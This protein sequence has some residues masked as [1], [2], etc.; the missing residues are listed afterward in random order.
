MA[1]RR[2]APAHRV[3]GQAHPRPIQDGG[4]VDVGEQRGEVAVPG[5]LGVEHGL[6]ERA[7]LQGVVGSH[8]VDRP[9][10]HDD[11]DEPALLEQLA[12]GGGVEPVEPRP[13]REVGIE[14]VLG[15]HPDQVRDRV[16]RRKRRPL[17]QELAGQRR[18]VEGTAIEDERRHARHHATVGPTGTL[19]TWNRP[20]PIRPSC[21]PSG[22]S[23][24]TARRRPAGCS[25]T[26]RPPG[27]TRCCATSRPKR[28]CRRLR[29]GGMSRA[30]QRPAGRR[31]GAQRIP[32]PLSCREGAP[33]PWAGALDRDVDLSLAAVAGAVAATGPP[34]LSPLEGTPVRASAV[35]APLYE[36]D[37]ET[38]IVLTRRAQDLRTHR[39]EV[40]F[41][42]GGSEPGDAD[43]WATALR[44]SH[45]E[46]ALDP[47]SVTRIGELDHLQTITSRSFIVPFVGTLPGRP[48]LVPHPSEVELVLHVP[49]R[50]LLTDGVHRSEHWGI[51]PLDHPVHFFEIVG[52]TI[53]GATGAMLD[54]LLTIIAGPSARVSPDLDPAR[55]EARRFDGRGFV[56][57]YVHEGQGGV[58]VLLVHG[59]PETKRIYWRVVGRWSTPASR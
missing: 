7:Q 23:G 24:K 33:A 17:Q 37:G 28:G 21:S 8:Q 25:P 22:T 20:R 9:P 27:S 36:A 57:A 11:A 50:E 47:S 42:G 58:P 16:E 44:E 18:P 34:R 41:P 54:N 2:L 43:L 55:F 30:D 35:L 4:H 31:G 3:L 52:D 15:L 53:W 12:D 29:H 13:Q 14:R 5:Y 40:S 10:H 6:G 19:S 1:A 49:V 38:V 48:E 46:V 51:P 45:E 59:W 26:S 39:G 32:R 56:Q